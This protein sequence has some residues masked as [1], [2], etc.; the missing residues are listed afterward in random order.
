MQKMNT[1][2][3]V[4]V[5]ACVLVSCGGSHFRMKT[6]HLQK[7]AANTPIRDTLVIVAVDDHEIRSL[8]ENYFKKRLT[9]EGVKAIPSIAERSL[10]E[11]TKLKKQAIVDV[12]DKHGNDSVL[13]TRLVGF[14]DTEAFSR[15]LPQAYRDLGD[16][17]KYAWGYIHWPTTYSD[18]VTLTIETRLYDVATESL[19]WTGESRLTNPE[20]RGKAI[21]QVVDGVIKELAKNGLLP[22]QS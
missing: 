13:F 18:T 11:G 14:N 15:D 7:A 20:T 1:T 3:L 4:A 16:F 17:D 10:Q 9:A 6:T 19:I 12:A 5:L 2:L 8:F 21:G 22:D